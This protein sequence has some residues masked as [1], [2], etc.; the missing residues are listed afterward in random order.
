MHAL[1]I[2]TYVY[3]HVCICEA[4]YVYLCTY[5]CSYTYILLQILMNVW[6]IM[7]RAPI[8]VSI[9]Q[10]AIFVS[11]LLDISFN[12]TTVTVKVSVAV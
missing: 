6:I 8:T 1:Y 10:E 9:Q 11:V 5:V 3:T 2:C 7:D 4:V 12:S